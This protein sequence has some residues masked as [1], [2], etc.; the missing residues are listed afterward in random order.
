MKG[1]LLRVYLPRHG[2][3]DV[4]LN[5][6]GEDLALGT[7]LTTVESRAWN[8]D[9]YHFVFGAW[10]KFDPSRPAGARAREVDVMILDTHADM[11]HFIEIKGGDGLYD[12]K[13]WRTW[14]NRDPFEQVEGAAERVVEGLAGHLAAKG[15]GGRLAYRTF[16]WG[17]EQSRDALKPL[18]APDRACRLIGMENNP[19]AY[20]RKNVRLFPPP[21]G[22]LLR[23]S[24]HID[25]FLTYFD[26]A[27]FPDRLLMEG[28]T[29]V[30]RALAARTAPSDP[31][32]E[33]RIT[34][35][36]MRADAPKPRP[37]AARRRSA[38]FLVADVVDAGLDGLLEAVGRS[39]R[40]ILRAFHLTVIAVGAL[41]VL[42]LVLLRHDSRT[43]PAQLGPA[44]LAGEGDLILPVVARTPIHTDERPLQATAFAP[45]CRLKTE[46][47][48]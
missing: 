47:A 36:T 5:S 11:L 7:I 12:G 32:D 29:A 13:T 33:A 25:E 6:R 42:Y 37:W 40:F 44:W 41:A 2:R 21:E 45:T 38:V 4:V 22:D 28:P 48:R 43:L 35:A 17:P 16:V 20:I 39:L 10:S 30:R 9:G 14:D 34:A 19:L 31:M 8:S 18:L 1:S 3:K 46:S 24:H 23:L 26:R 15:I 27:V